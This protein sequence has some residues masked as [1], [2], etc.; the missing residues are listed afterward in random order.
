MRDGRAALLALEELRGR[1][2]GIFGFLMDLVEAGV[3]GENEAGEA[4][5]AIVGAVGV[6]VKLPTWWPS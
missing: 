4:A 1:V 2:L 6:S 5:K 3:V